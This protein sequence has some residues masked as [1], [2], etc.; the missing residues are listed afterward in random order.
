MAKI[1]ITM[2]LTR[3]YTP[4]IDFYPEGCSLQ[5]AGDIDLAG[6]KENPDLFMDW[7]DARISWK[8]ECI[9]DIPAH[10]DGQ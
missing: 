8:L 5:E 7:G 6:A 10:E 4:N 9:P 2:T 1:R 3:E